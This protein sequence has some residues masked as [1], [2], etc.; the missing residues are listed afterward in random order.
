MKGLEHHRDAKAVLYRHALPYPETGRPGARPSLAGTRPEAM[1]RDRL[2]LRPLDAGHCRPKLRPPP[3]PAFSPRLV[4]RCWLA[5]AGRH[6]RCGSLAE[7]GSALRMA[8]LRHRRSIN[9]VSGG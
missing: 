8:V 5:S 4:L 1:R 9:G 3:N 7:G 2:E 6:F